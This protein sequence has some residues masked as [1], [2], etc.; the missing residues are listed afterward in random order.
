MGST[1]YD[2]ARDPNDPTWAGASWYGPST[3]EYWIINPREYADP[4]KH[5]PAYQQRARQAAAGIAGDAIEDEAVTAGPTQAAEGA[6]GTLGGEA[7]VHAS[8]GQA[9]TYDSRTAREREPRVS[10]AQARER[11]QARA[12]EAMR[13]QAPARP[14]SSASVHPGEAAPAPG[15]LPALN[16]SPREWIGG[17]ADDPIR[18]LGIALVAWPPLGLAAAAVIGDLTGCSTFS[19]SCGGSEPLLPWLAQAGILGLLLLLPPIARLLAGGSMAVFLALI[20]ISAFLL[21]VGGAGA[22]QAG[23]ALWF[24]LAV[25]WIAG[26]AWSLVE[27]RRRRAAV[28]MGPGART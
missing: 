24:L 14:W 13:G 23:T 6:S 9:W 27:L 2:E 5:G 16:A 20:P 11:E 7:P 25:A 26:I 4:R 18:R 8:A 21:A 17:P 12:R 15:M 22:P 19:A 10:R 1:S 3:G 28:P